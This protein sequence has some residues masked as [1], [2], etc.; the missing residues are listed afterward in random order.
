M[1]D[2]LTKSLSVSNAG[3]FV[4]IQWSI[5]IQCDGLI[6]R[7]LLAWSAAYYQ[8]ELKFVLTHSRFGYEHWLILS[9]TKNPTMSCLLTFKLFHF[10]QRSQERSCCVYSRWV[11]HL[12]H[13]YLPFQT[14]KKLFEVEMA[15]T[16][17]SVFLLLRGMLALRTFF[18]P[19]TCELIYDISWYRV[20]PPFRHLSRLLLK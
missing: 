9:Y 4:L 16:A 14:R 5:M 11:T 19:L 18:Y 12:T 10:L 13:A 17:L 3:V 8:C 20:E 2:G 1:I 7:F 15:N 6:L